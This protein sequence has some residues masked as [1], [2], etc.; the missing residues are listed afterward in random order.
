MLLDGEY[1]MSINFCGQPDLKKRFHIHS[2]LTVLEAQWVGKQR[3]A[4]LVS[5]PPADPKLL[6]LTQPGLMPMESWLWNEAIG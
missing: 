6:L 5:Y 3:C 2:E 4:E 1:K